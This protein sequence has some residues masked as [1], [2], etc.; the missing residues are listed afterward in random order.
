MPQTPSKRLWTVKRSS[1]HNRGIFAKH[2]I[3]KDTPVIEYIGEKIT[4]AESRRRGDA[5]IAKSKKTGGAAVY[6][7]TL[8]Q[9]YDIDGAKGRNPA[10]YINHSC[11]P[12]CEAYIIRGRIWIYSLREI[13]AGEEL[14]Y[15]YGFDA[16]T[17]DEHPC[18]CGSER[19]IG[20]IV[21]EKQWPKL[22]RIFEK[23]EAKARAQK[24]NGATTALPRK[25]KAA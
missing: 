17:W 1:I 18:R 20:Y 4:K 7:F 12:N 8:N 6:I 24:V 14:T 21:E 11:D 3:P 15:N 19:C 9:R 13:A 22:L 2:D 25:R 23:M 10:R 16:D 5:L